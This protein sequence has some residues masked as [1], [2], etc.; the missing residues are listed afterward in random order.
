MR[1][2]PTPARIALATVVLRYRNACREH[3]RAAETMGDG[4]VVTMC[5]EARRTELWNTLQ[6]MRTNL[7]DEQKGD[8]VSVGKP[9][10]FLR[11]V[12]KGAEIRRR[13]ALSRVA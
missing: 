11:Y 2:L 8:R 5:A 1:S 9:R 13:V 4:N 6:A 7:H 3:K 12:A 10:E